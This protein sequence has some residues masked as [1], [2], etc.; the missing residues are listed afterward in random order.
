MPPLCKENNTQEL[1]EKQVK[2]E[3]SSLYCRIE[4]RTHCR[5]NVKYQAETLPYQRPKAVNRRTNPLKKPQ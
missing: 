2:S 4:Y 3:V 5:A 1:A